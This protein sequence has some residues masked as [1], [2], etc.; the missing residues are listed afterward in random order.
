M[1][2]LKRNKSDRERQTLQD[3]TRMWNLK[4]SNNK[5]NKTKPTDTENTLVVTRGEW[6]QLYGEGW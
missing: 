3:F 4:N 6:G 1:D 2:G 5:M